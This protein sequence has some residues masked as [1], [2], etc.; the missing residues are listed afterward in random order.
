MSVRY[1]IYPMRIAKYSL[2]G[3]LKMSPASEI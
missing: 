2:Y 1:L 3:N